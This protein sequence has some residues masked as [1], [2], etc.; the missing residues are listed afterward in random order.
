MQHDKVCSNIHWNLL[1]TFNLN[2]ST[3]HWEHE[4]AKFTTTGEIDIYYDK[5][6]ELGS[7][8]K[9]GQTELI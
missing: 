8:I 1:G 7:F 4:L 9:T 3:K 6:V 2:R 5:E